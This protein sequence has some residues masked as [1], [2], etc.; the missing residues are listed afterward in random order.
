MY[1]IEDELDDDESFVITK[2]SDFQSESLHSSTK[3][4]NQLVNELSTIN[5]INLFSLDH[6]KALEDS[7]GDALIK[8]D[9]GEVDSNKRLSFQS[10]SP[11][12]VQPFYSEI[13]SRFI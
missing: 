10:S 7:E 4:S 11:N 3:S 9:F 12:T 6:S 8:E 13:Q 5:N 1:S 2:D